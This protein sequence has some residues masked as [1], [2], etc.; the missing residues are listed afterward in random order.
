M[1]D[2]CEEGG[3]FLCLCKLT[4][5]RQPLP[6]QT[7]SERELLY[8]LRVRTRAQQSTRRREESYQLPHIN[9]EE[10]ELSSSRPIYSPKSAC[11]SSLKSWLR[12]EREVRLRRR[13][14]NSP[15]RD[16][17]CRHQGIRAPTPSPYQ[18]SRILPHRNRI[19]TSGRQQTT[20]I[21]WINSK[22]QSGKL[23]VVLRARGA[24]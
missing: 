21:R 18:H 22:A 14:S 8:S 3:L 10:W 5:A 20:R 1:M 19:V 11:A 7:L 17:R 13:A 15:P 24:R 2:Y 12:T 4:V 23:K 16:C 6:P 9:H